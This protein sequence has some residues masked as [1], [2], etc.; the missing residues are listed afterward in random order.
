MTLYRLAATPHGG[1]ELFRATAQKCTEMTGPAIGRYMCGVPPA[2]PTVT[3]P[4]SPQS[5]SAD[6]RT[7]A[8][9]P[10]R[11]GMVPSHLTATCS[12]LGGMLTPHPRRADGASGG[13]LS[14]WVP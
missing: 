6:G 8:T 11:V 5:S 14:A 3:N 10:L 12:L 2:P 7:V 4:V 13:R 9:S 1:L